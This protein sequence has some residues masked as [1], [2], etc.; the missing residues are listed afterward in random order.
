ML[1]ILKFPDPRLRMKA[2]NLKFLDRE[3]QLYFGQMKELMYEADGIGLAATQVGIPLRF[4]VCDLSEDKNKPFVVINPKIV[5]VGGDEE[6]IFE[7]GCL[8]IPGFKIPVRRKKKIFVKWVDE[9]GEEHEEELENLKSVLFQHEID[10]LDGKLI[11]DKLSPDE[12]REILKNF[13]QYE[14]LDRNTK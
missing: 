6:I 7:E 10:H 1:K 2:K 5:S 11:I 3:I 13:P 14:D 4:F 12:R 8:S 9:K